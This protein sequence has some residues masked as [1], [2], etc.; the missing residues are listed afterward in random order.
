LRLSVNLEARRAAG[1][2]EARHPDGEVAERGRAERRE[3]ADEGV[4]E[5]GEVVAEILLAEL[6]RLGDEGIFQRSLHPTLDQRLFFFSEQLGEP[7][8]GGER[9]RTFHEPGERVERASPNVNV[10]S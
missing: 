9:R 6:P 3:R 8:A 1:E 2:W 5:P 7:T 4:D 10:A